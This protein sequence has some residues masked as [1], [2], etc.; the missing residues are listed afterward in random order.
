MTEPQTRS[1][2]NKAPG[3]RFRDLAVLLPCL[4]VL[5]LATPIVSIFTQS[6]RILGL[7]AP[8]F[9]IFGIWAG[10]IILAFGLARRINRAN[11][12]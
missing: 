7:P 2:P 5:L 11:R 4:G 9:Y 10:L 1:V 3:R 12:Q 8:I 6:G